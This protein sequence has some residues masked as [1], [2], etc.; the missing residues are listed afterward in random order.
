MKIWW[1]CTAFLLLVYSLGKKVWCERD[2]E[3]PLLPCSGEI[4]VSR[5]CSPPHALLMCSLYWHSSWVVFEEPP[6]LHPSPCCLQL[7]CS[8]SWWCLTLLPLL[9]KV[10]PV[11]ILNKLW[12][13]LTKDIWEEV[14]GFYLCTPFPASPP[15]LQPEK[16]IQR[17]ENKL[18]LLF[19]LSLLLA[20]G[21]RHWICSLLRPEGGEQAV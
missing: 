13:E 6:V 4:L 11:E 16:P 14:P 9:A 7:S 20:A 1:N 3:W 8:S 17:K 12:R 2:V 10:I 21:R 15:S 19:H 5:L 18:G